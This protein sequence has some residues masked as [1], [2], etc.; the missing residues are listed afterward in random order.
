M[1]QYNPLY[2]ITTYTNISILYLYLKVSY[3]QNLLITILRFILKCT[4]ESVNLNNSENDN[5]TIVNM[6][7][8]VRCKYYGKNKQYNKQFCSDKEYRNYKKWITSQK[9]YSNFQFLKQVTET[10]DSIDVDRKVKKKSKRDYLY[11][12]MLLTK[13]DIKFESIVYCL[14]DKDEIV[15]VGVSK[16]LQTRIQNHI[17]DSSKEFDSWNILKRIPPHFTHSDVSEYESNY[18]KMFKPKYNKV[19]NKPVDRQV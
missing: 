2:Q 3:K 14:I 5:K 8:I 4:W 17:K 9:G 10:K 7:Y 15:Y 18:I 12:K 11:N 6:K 13:R 1:Y 19:H 16:N